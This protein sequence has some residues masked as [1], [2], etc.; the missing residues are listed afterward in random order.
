MQKQ[1]VTPDEVSPKR[2]PLFSMDRES[3]RWEDEGGYDLAMA[4][5]RETLT[6]RR[7]RLLDKLNRL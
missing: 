7:G 3:S 6:S 4:A 2:N 1:S 5:V